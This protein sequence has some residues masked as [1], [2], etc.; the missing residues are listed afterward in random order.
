MTTGLQPALSN[1][2]SAWCTASVSLKS[3]KTS[4]RLIKKSAAVLPSI[5]TAA[6]TLSGTTSPTAGARIAIGDERA[7]SASAIGDRRSIDW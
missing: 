6:R 3:S 7:T 1:A 4:S 2:P 5:P